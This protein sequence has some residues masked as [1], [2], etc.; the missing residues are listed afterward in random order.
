MIKDA[1]YKAEVPN[2]SED[3]ESSEFE[4]VV[5]LVTDLIHSLE[6]KIYQNYG[7]VIDRGKTKH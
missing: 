2:F 1:I 7:K 6:M 4:H 5:G 3:C